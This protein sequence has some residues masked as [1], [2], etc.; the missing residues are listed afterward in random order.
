MRF[1][2][3]IGLTAARVGRGSLVPADAVVAARAAVSRLPD[4]EW[5]DVEYLGALPE[6]LEDRWLSVYVSGRAEALPEAEADR[7]RAAV[8]AAVFEALGSQPFV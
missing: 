1:D 8:T 4:A 2:V 6:L 7:A 5:V 3:S